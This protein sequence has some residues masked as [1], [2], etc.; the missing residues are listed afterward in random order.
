MISPDPTLAALRFCF[1]VAWPRLNNWWAQPR[2]STHFHSRQKISP[3]SNRHA[4]WANIIEAHHEEG[5]PSKDGCPK[6]IPWALKR[7]HKSLNKYQ[8]LQPLLNSIILSLL[9]SMPPI[10]WI[11][12]T[13]SPNTSTS[14]ASLTMAN[15]GPTSRR[16]ALVAS[17]RAVLS[18][19]GGCIEKHV[20]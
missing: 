19:L 9:A 5:Y 13:Y 3:S 6:S 8:Y 15:A 20:D 14:T 2:H 18:D 1:P 16:N 7:R 11:N 10:P 12:K 4:I 17:V